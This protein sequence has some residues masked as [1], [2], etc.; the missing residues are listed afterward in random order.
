MKS[1]LIRITSAA[2]VTAN[3]L[4]VLEAGADDFVSANGLD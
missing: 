3:V 4:V 2:V 1:S